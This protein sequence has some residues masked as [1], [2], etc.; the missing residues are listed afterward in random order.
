MMKC[1]ETVKIETVNRF[2]TDEPIIGILNKEDGLEHPRKRVL[3][4]DRNSLGADVLA[5]RTQDGFREQQQLLLTEPHHRHHLR[6]DGIW[7]ILD[8]SAPLPSTFGSFTVVIQKT[9]LV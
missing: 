1:I 8:S 5:S 9:M 3:S 4:T 2:W 6:G 7:F